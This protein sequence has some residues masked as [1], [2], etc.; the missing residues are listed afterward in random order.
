MTDLSAAGGAGCTSGW[1]SGLQPPT[2]KGAR[3]LLVSNRVAQW[4]YAQ[5]EAVG[6]L[7]WLQADDM[8]P[9]DSRWRDL[10]VGW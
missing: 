9:L 2:N 4:A 3:R 1:G 5:T 8:V 10:V 6:G 7:T